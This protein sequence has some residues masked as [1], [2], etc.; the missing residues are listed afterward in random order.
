MFGVDTTVPDIR[1]PSCVKLQLSIR[2]TAN[3][4]HPRI[5]SVSMKTDVFSKEA[6]TSKIFAKVAVLARIYVCFLEKL[7]FLL[8]SAGMECRIC[9]L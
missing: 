5:Q 6:M 8:S 1:L 2:P 4:L 9:L 3:L 7:L